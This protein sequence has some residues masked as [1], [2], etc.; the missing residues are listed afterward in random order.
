MKLGQND[1]PVRRQFSNLA[2][3]ILAVCNLAVS[4][5]AVCNLAVGNLA[6]F[7]IC[8]QCDTKIPLKILPEKR[9]SQL[10]ISKIKI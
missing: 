2:V 4:I 10:K 5:L 9:I 8:H 3:S 7:N 1:R 6:V